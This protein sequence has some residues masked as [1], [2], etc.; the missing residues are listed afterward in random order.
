MRQE[1]AHIS[2]NSRTKEALD[3][4]RAPG[5]S[6]DGVIQQLI[7][8]WDKQSELDEVSGHQSHGSHSSPSNNR[9]P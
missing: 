6:Y 1:R 4:I 3:L 8:L 9:V 2:L 7:K 5:Q